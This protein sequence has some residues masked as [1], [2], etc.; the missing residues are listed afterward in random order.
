MLRCTCESLAAAEARASRTRAVTPTPEPAQAANQAWAAR[1]YSVM[2]ELLQRLRAA[3]AT[4]PPEQKALVDAIAPEVGSTSY[5]CACPGSVW[6]AGCRGN[7]LACIRIVSSS[8]AGCGSTAD[9]CCRGPGSAE[10][11]GF[12]KQML[13]C[14]GPRSPA[15]SCCWL[16]RQLP[17]AGS[18]LVELLGSRSPCLALCGRASMW[19]SWCWPARDTPSAGWRSRS[20]S[21]GWR[22][23]LPAAVPASACR[24]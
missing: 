16:R 13:R 11:A 21:N 5:I 17:G 22:R 7:P 18:L 14:S 4:L 24:R 1:Q 8:R 12:L 23:A 9:P 2:A 19:A 6:S 15:T 20:T 10:L 3:V